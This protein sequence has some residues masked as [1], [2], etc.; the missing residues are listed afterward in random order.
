[1]EIVGEETLVVDVFDVERTPATSWR[2]F[3]GTNWASWA[4]CV[5]VQS[6]QSIGVVWYMDSEGCSA[7]RTDRDSCTGVGRSSSG[8]VDAGRGEEEE[9]GDVEEESGVKE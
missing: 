1:M 9:T 8:S 4:C 7:E 6:E 3:F 2:L 5:V